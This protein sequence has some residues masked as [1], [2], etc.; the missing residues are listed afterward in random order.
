MVVHGIGARRTP[1]SVPYLGSMVQAVV[2]PTSP[3]IQ[4]RPQCVLN[5]IRQQKGFF[6]CHWRQ[7]ALLTADGGFLRVLLIDVVEVAFFCTFIVI[8]IRPLIP[9]R[10]QHHRVPF[11]AMHHR[12]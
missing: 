6:P 4:N 9:I 12:V 10:V 11:Q 3:R 8:A 5:A 1:Y 7:G 2:C